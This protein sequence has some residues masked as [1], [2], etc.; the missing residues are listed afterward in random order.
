KDPRALDQYYEATALEGGH[1]TTVRI[2]LRRAMNALL[3]ESYHADC[4]R[5]CARWNRTLAEHGLSERLTLP[6]V[7]F[8]RQIGL[9][10]GQ[11][12]G[13]DGE[14]IE[15]ER[16]AGEIARHLPTREDYDYVRSVMVPVRERGRFANWIAPPHQGINNQPIDFEYVQFH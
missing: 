10:A 14:P 2:P 6:S 3:L 11:P 8:A 12:F 4:E 13:Y 16:V 15:P 9:Y 5:I 1:T 7:R